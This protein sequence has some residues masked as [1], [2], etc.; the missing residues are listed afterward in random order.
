MKSTR[1]RSDEI[2]AIVERRKT[3]ILRPLSVQ[4]PDG[5]VFNGL[6][7]ASDKGLFMPPG[8]LGT[9]NNKNSISLKPPYIPSQF[10]WVR[11]RFA[12]VMGGEPFGY[13]VYKS[14]RETTTLE[15]SEIIK[16]EELKWLHASDMEEKYSRVAFKVT[17]VTAKHINDLSPTEMM[18]VGT[19]NFKVEWDLRYFKKGLDTEKNPLVWVIA[20]KAGVNGRWI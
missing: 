13:S 1:L 3:I 16:E 7:F 12:K 4:P 6:S 10:Y 11:E 19:G 14:G 2:T 9:L 17:S 15:S 20:I 18:Q 5:F 8:A